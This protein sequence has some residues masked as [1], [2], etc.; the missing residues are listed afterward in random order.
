MTISPRQAVAHASTRS[1]GRICTSASRRTA[2][3]G[4]VRQ[5][6]LE[7]FQ[8]SGHFRSERAKQECIN[9]SAAVGILAAKIVVSLD[10]LLEAVNGIFHPRN[11]L[12]EP[13]TQRGQRDS[14]QRL[15]QSF[16]TSEVIVKR[17]LGDPGRLDDLA[18]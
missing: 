4:P 18:H 2:A 9:E 13:S 12:L 8:L 14:D 5:A 10:H 6:F 11:D 3:L 17:G 7:W 16:F 1:Q 15:G